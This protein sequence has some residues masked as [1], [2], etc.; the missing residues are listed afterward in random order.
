M[1]QI[2]QQTDEETQQ[3]HQAADSLQQFMNW[4]AT[5]G[6][7]VGAFRP[8]RGMQHPECYVETPYDWDRLLHQ[9]FR[10]TPT[11]DPQ[12]MQFPQTGG[13]CEFKP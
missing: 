12:Q 4:A 6:Y 5:Q 13:Y 9:Y 7:Q 2:H 11:T 10:L 1:T 3:L 8:H